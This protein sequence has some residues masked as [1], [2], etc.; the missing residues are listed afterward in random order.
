MVLAFTI[1]EST[2]ND[3]PFPEAAILYSGRNDAVSDAFLFTQRSRLRYPNVS[4]EWTAA[5][6]LMPHIWAHCSTPSQTSLALL[7][8]LCTLTYGNVL[9]D[10]H[11]G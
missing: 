2:R 10:S 4:I 9:L 7:P 1:L 8:Y 6:R 11:D 5:D 3:D